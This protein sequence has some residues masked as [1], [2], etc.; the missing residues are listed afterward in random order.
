MYF[1]T[2]TDKG[3]IPQTPSSGYMLHILMNNGSSEMADKRA[4]ATQQKSIHH[5]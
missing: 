1:H 2:D 3:L 5:I 4:K